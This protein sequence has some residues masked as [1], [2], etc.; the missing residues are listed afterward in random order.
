MQKKIRGKSLENRFEKILSLPVT[1]HSVAGGD[2]NGE[3]ADFETNQTLLTV[4]Q[5]RS[6]LEL[7][8]GSSSSHRPGQD[9]LRTAISAFQFTST[10]SPPLESQF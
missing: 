10:T 1:R 8:Q 3:S 7:R 4:R 9:Q 6:E 5:I 2:D